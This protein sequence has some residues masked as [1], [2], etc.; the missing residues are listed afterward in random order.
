MS[1]LVAS[2]YWPPPDGRFLRAV[3]IFLAVVVIMTLLGM[4]TTN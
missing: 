3:I 2:G 1:G 4:G